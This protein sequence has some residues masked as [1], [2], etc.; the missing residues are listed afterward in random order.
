MKRLP[1][2]LI[3]SVQNPFKHRPSLAMCSLQF[4]KNVSHPQPSYAG[5]RK[6]EKREMVCVYVCVCVWPAKQKTRHKSSTIS[7]NA[8]NPHHETQS[9]EASP[10]SFNSLTPLHTSSH[11]FTVHRLCIVF[12]ALALRTGTTPVPIPNQHSTLRDLII[13]K[14]DIRRG[15]ATMSDR[16]GR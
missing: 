3:K 15:T 13:S 12:S 9:P 10:E 6:R 4:A 16:S 5:K 11:N 2:P 1:P 8:H 7:P 14:S